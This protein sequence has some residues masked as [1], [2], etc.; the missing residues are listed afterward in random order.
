MTKPQTQGVA[1][2]QKQELPSVEQHSILPLTFTQ[3][4]LEAQEIIQDEAAALNVLASQLDGRFCD[5]V[6]LI[7]ETTGTV[8]VTG[9]GKA[10][11]IGQ[12]IVATLSS[13]GTKSMFLHPTEALHGDL[14]CLTANDIVL[15]FSNSGRSEEVLKLLPILNRRRTP[16][17]AITRDLESD[18]AKA[19]TIVLEIGRHSEAGQLRLAPSVSTTVML[20]MGDA[21]ALVVSQAKGFG[22]LDFAESHPAGN[23]GRQFQS[24]AEVMRTGSELRTA[25]DCET[26]RSVM[27]ERSPSGRR[28]GA[29]LLT[30][31]TGRLSGIFT[32]SDLARLFEQ[33]RDHLIDCA[34]AEVM[35]VNPTTIHESAMLPEAVSV[36]KKTKISELP[37]VT[38]SGAP[39]GLVDITDVIDVAPMA[40]SVD[41]SESSHSKAA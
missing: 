21:L 3:Q 8:V 12:K 36:L 40:R 10:G 17:I 6:R 32:D 2:G 24:V 19:A 23:L 25:R 37:V 13:T 30:D 7:L 9:V 4:L 41:S 27:I 39:I 28:T 33:R 26:V 34:I 1:S 15:A 29:V 5:A 16:F 31:A 35:S 11:L 20:A 38:D 18:F 14:G 22:Q